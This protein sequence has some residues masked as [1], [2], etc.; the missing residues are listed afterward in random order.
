MAVIFD[1][2]LAPSRLHISLQRV[3]ARCQISEDQ[4]LVLE[5]LGAEKTELVPKKRSRREEALV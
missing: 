5:V 2:G 1:A 3:P 4:V